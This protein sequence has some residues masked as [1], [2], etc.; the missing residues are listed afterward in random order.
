M[1]ELELSNGKS[2]F[3]FFD[4][5]PET[6]TSNRTKHQTGDFRLLPLSEFYKP[7]SLT[8][9]YRVDYE[10]LFQVAGSFRTKHGITPS[11]ADQQSTWLL[12]VDVQNT[13][14]IPGF[15]LYVGGRSGNG[16]VDD[17]RR[18]CAFIYHNLS[19]ITSISA[20]LD[21]HYIFQIFHPLFFVN[22]L[23][24]NPAPYTNIHLEDLVAGKWKFNPAL[25]GQ[26]GITAEYG[27]RLVLH[28]AETLAENGK[29]ELT[30]W[31]HHAM[32]GGIGHA[33]VSAIEE[34]IFFH[35]S[36]RLSQP[37]FIIKGNNPFTENYSVLGPEVLNGPKGESL[38][39]HNFK[40]LEKLK[41]VDRMIIAG[42]AKSH[43]VSWTVE[44]LLTDIQEVDPMLAQ[45][46]YLL[47]DCTSA[48]VVPGLMDY[49][50]SANA[51]FTKFSEAGM[52]L[53][54]STSLIENW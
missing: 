9:V 15:E 47:E 44:D 32:L 27:Q 10:N 17:N 37:E 23:G 35:S 51:Q 26:L 48:V 50:D 40:I 6:Y 7:D 18:L 24:E 29:Y 36:V 8:Q 54:Q 34:A 21:T 1:F 4:R 13:F 19:S 5:A 12:L 16:A 14:C 39:H 52:H 3:S 49:T 43:C 11:S 45:K 33:L 20:T 42:Q 2:I 25:A 53:V 22:S 41:K 46:I 38:G 31:P 30:I 28:Y